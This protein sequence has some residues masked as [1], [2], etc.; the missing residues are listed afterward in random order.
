LALAALTVRFFLRNYPDKTRH[1]WMMAQ[2]TLINGLA[3]D[4]ISFFD[5]GLQYGDGL[6]ETIAVEDSSLL[7]WGEHLDRLEQGCKRLNISCPDSTILKDEAISLINSNT[8]GVIKIIITRG[9]GGRGYVLPDLDKPSRIIS[10]YPWP[11]YPCEN[12]SAGIKVRLCDYRYSRNST[13]AGIKHLNRLEQV[14]ARA[15][16]TDDSIAEGIVMDQ[17]E[18][19]VEGT[20]SNLFYLANNILTTPD[21]STCGVDGIIRNKIIELATKLNIDVEIKKISIESLMKA[22]EIFVCNSI[23]GVWPVNTIGEKIFSVGKD[24]QQITQALQEKNYIS[25]PC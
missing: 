15:E 11:E 16:W 13:L 7:C 23:I 5:R 10:L 19:V 2:H 12:Y 14:L 8:R 1:N 3:T 25:L 17:E 4:E 9:Q 21:L 18:N 20:M 24:T 22:D 6:F